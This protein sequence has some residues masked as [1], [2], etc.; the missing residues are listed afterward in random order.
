MRESERE[1]A[2]LT[3]AETPSLDRIFDLLSDRRRRYTLYCLYDSEN[4][5]ATIED[6]VEYVLSLE[7]SGNSPE[8][9]DQL[10]TSLEHMHLPRLEDAGIVEYDTRSD[11]VRYWGQPSLEEWL[12]HA[13]HK[14]LS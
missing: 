5:V 4:G 8:R 6:I 11:T 3:A 10:L 12:E 7:A 9:R 13:R 2:Q 14:E 1:V